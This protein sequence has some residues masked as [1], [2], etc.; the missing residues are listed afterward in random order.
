MV[1]FILML[2]PFTFSTSAFV[3]AGVLQPMASDLGISIGAAGQLQTAFALSCAVGGPLLASLTGRFERKALLSFVLAT[4]MVANIACANAESYPAILVVRVIAG[5]IGALTLPLA[6]TIAIAMVPQERAP[7]ALA[8]VMA[9]I[10]V[11]FLVGI[12][13]GSVVGEQFGWHA[14]FWLAACIAGI[15]LLA[16]TIGVPTVGRHPSSERQ[17]MRT[18]LRWPLLGYFGLTFFSFSGTFTTIAYV[19]PIV[20][21]F[22]GLGGS[23]IGAVQFCVGIGGL[24]GLTLGAIVSRR[25][26]PMIAILMSVI[27]LIQALYTLGLVAGLHGTAG[28]AFVILAGLGG[29]VALFA[30]SP[31]LQTQIAVLS[32]SA[33]TL[34]FALNG[35][36]VFMG[37]GSGAAL[38]GLV[39]ATLGLHALG[40]VGAGIASIGVVLAFIVHRDRVNAE[41]GGERPDLLASATD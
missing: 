12:P 16:V 23:G 29:S 31:I 13:M 15:A 24:L 20:T 36:M 35:S 2:A 1:L 10:S 33:A 4:L 3:F 41:R 7:V 14:S 28:L 19:G 6:S 37:Q 27:I 39:S 26:G 25:R 5:F 32:G 9:G 18:I 30:L 21:E 34:A 40:L 11:A 38:G 22:T 8:T 17:A